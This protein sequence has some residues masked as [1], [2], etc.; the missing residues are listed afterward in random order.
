MKIKVIGIG[1]AGSNTIS[2][3]VKKG[4]SDIE[5]IAVNTDAQAL[6]NCS[7]PKKILIGQRT[8]SGLGVGMDIRLGLMATKESQEKLKEILKGADMVFLTAGLGGGTGTSGLPILAEI[9]KSLGALTVA[10][11][12]KPF[13]F[14]GTQRQ[15]IANWGFKK[16]EK[17]VDAY[18]CIKNDRILDLIG[19]QISVEEAFLKIDSILSFALE[20]ISKVL[21]SPGII[22]V[23]FADLQKILKN[24]GKV[25]FGQGVAKGEQRAVSAASKALQFPLLDFSPKRAKGILFNISGKDVSLFEVNLIANFIKR[26]ADKNSKIIF[27]IGENENLEKGEIKVTLIATGV[28]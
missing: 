15:R 19:K 21:F 14:E 2:R 1:G 23:D 25:L 16:L 28:E 8:T 12:T 13:S 10:I 7:S 26:I 27:G 3:L 20:G 5:L 22:R 17:K 6:R 18:F 4:I 24:S 11:V 9:A